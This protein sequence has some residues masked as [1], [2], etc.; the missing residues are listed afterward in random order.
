MNLNSKIIL[1]LVALIVAL[2][3]A[4]YGGYKLGNNQSNSESITNSDDTTTASDSIDNTTIATNSDTMTTEAVNP[5]AA[6]TLADACSHLVL[7]MGSSEGAAGTNYTHAVI[8]NNGDQDCS[9]SG[10]PTATMS[11]TA[12]QSITAENNSLYPVDL[13][14]ITASGGQA[15][16]VL[17]LPNAGNLDPATT[18]CTAA[19]TTSLQLNLP[20][21]DAIL[22][23]SFPESACQGFTVTALHSGA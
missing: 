13:V 20:G 4:V 7:S 19:A 1:L 3:L 21:V 17:G 18:D 6:T 11:D 23:A 2:A 15:H 8:T 9:L 10:Y 12:G 5:D 22:N 16:V 14:T